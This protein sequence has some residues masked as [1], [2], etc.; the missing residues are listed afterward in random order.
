MDKIIISNLLTA[1]IIGVDHPE[2][3][4]PQSILI[5]L[6]LY[7]DTYKAGKSDNIFD[8]VNYVSVIKAIKEQVS[9]SN[10]FTVE[11]LAEHLSEYILSVFPVKFVRLKVEK[12][13]VVKSTQSVGIEIFRS[14]NDNR[15]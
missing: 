1:G 8:T 14:R 9:I 4:Q 6:T 11:A 2:R 3:D 10:Y 5:N 12:P 7:L 13:N 15:I